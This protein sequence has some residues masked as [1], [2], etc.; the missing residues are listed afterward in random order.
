MKASGLEEIF[1]VDP[2]EKNEDKELVIIEEDSNNLPE[3]A[4]E[5]LP[6]SNFI[7]SNLKTLVDKANTA[8]DKAI[9][10]QQEETIPRNSE[11]VSTLISGVDKAL[12]T[13]MMLNK[14]EKESKPRSDSGTNPHI[15]NSQVV[16]ATSEEIISKI[17]NSVN[18][19]G[20]D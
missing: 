5:N 4:I 10:A 7:R 13:L 11:A 20:E 16:I 12:N 15:N 9:V 18:E 2:I 8:L 17:I 1:N 14:A 6:D 19:D 3:T